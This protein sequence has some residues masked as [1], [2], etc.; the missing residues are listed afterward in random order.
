M[1]REGQYSDSREHVIHFLSVQFHAM[2]SA[3]ISVSVL[4]LVGLHVLGQLVCPLRP[5]IIMLFRGHDDDSTG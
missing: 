1:L 2:H 5:E 4:Y 3:E